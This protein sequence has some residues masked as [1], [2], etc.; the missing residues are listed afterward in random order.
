MF[1]VLK[2]ESRRRL[3]GTMALAVLLGL[4]A[5]LIVGIYPSIQAAAADFE[6]AIQNL[7]PA[8]RE[9]FV[10][11]SYTTVEGFLST[12]LYQFLWLLLMG[13]Y[14]AYLAGGTIAGDAESG[15]LDMVLA[16]PVSRSRVLV[17]KYLSL[18]TPIVV[19]NLTMPLFVY[20][21][22]L[23]V[24]ESIDLFD[25]VAVHALSVPYLLVCG[26]VGLFLSVLVRRGDLAQ[27][28]GIA[29]VFVLFVLEAVTA[30]TDYEWLGALSPTR[31]YDPVSILVDEQ[32]D[33]AGAAILLAAAFAVVTV[34]QTIFENSDI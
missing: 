23:A 31:Y 10:G 14:A 33:L 25:L 3:R 9:G 19:L 16:T 4:F 18:L 27:R 17:E 7:P 30:D 32:Y 26:S 13:L 21:G 2:Y 12:E 34:S 1:E 24:G 20:G 8:I 15:R 28:G 29:A 11:G 6:A 5:L 22:L